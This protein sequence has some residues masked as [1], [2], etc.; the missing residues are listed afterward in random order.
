MLS[1]YIDLLWRSLW[2]IPGLLG[3]NVLGLIWPVLVVMCG[4]ILAA[5]YLGWLVV[6]NKWKR[7]SLIGLAALG[8]C[9]TGLLVWSVLHTV[10][11]D[12]VDLSA[13]VS[14][15][16]PRDTGLRVDVNQI[17][18][19]DFRGFRRFKKAEMIYINFD[20]SNPTGP[21]RFVRGWDMY[22]VTKGSRFQAVPFTPP[23]EQMRNSALGADMA[24][25]TPKEDRCPKVFVE[26]LP[27]GGSRNCWLSGVF[28][29]E[30]SNV[31]LKTSSVLIR[32]IDELTGKIYDSSY[33]LPSQPIQ[34]ESSVQ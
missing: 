15:L 32:F 4:E 17:S 12:H 33:P 20:I 30:R 18:E 19:G 2:A 25:L 13:K 21:P 10:Y 29:V 7:A 23:N 24:T 6:L 5:C 22:L 1:F 11:Q 28:E 14:Q 31:D 34:H 16:T 3:S 9:Y 27:T 8:V 26:P